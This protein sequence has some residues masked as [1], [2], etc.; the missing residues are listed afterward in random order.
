MTELQSEILQYGPE[1]LKRL[2]DP[3][4]PGAVLALV[5]VSHIV[6]AMKKEEEEGGG[7]DIDAATLL[8]LAG[9]A[10]DKAGGEVIF[11]RT[12]QYQA[13]IS[14]VKN[15]DAELVLHGELANLCLRYKELPAAAR[16]QTSPPE[17]EDDEKGKKP[18]SQD[19]A[20]DTHMYTD[21]E[22]AEARA[23]LMRQGVL[24]LVESLQDTL[25]IDLREVPMALPPDEKITA[26]QTLANNIPLAEALEK[27]RAK[28]DALDAALKSI[29]A[30]IDTLL[31]DLPSFAFSD[32]TEF[33][34]TTR[35]FDTLDSEEI[36]YSIL[37]ELQEQDEPNLAALR[38]LIAQQNLEEALD[39]EIKKIVNGPVLD[40][41]V[42]T[43][44]FR[45]ALPE[46]PSHLHRYLAERALREKLRQS[47]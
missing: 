31:D 40:S 3:L 12:L 15:Q 42:K 29:Q 7:G 27:K 4:I 18:A 6:E 17:E 2:I 45:E 21:E 20:A 23:E 16:G 38:A 25:T 14:R 35:S 39:G 34:D 47:M 5:A 33:S 22:L 1:R 9:P 30:S 46:Q 26:L 19:G 28:R 10:L 24:A 41:L 37:D 11:A 44:Q 36:V 8:E 43:P 13:A 32:N